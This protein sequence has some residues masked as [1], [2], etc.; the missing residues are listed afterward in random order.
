MPIVD[1]QIV[2]A[3]GAGPHLAAQPLADALGRVF[4][5]SAAGW[6]NSAPR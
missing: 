2:R 4:A 1:V 5:S 3:A 6:W